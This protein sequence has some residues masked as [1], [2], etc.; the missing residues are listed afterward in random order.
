M[1][2]MYIIYGSGLLIGGF[3]VLITLQVGTPINAAFIAFFSLVA[4]FLLHTNLSERKE[5]RTCPKCREWWEVE[6][7][8][9]LDSSDILLPPAIGDNVSVV[10]KFQCK[11]CNHSWDVLTYETR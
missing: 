3:S 11:R 6:K 10:Y 9:R 1:R 8:N 7:V 5:T 4:T 2:M